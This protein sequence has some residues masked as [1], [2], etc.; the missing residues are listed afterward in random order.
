MLKFLLVVIVV[1][2]GLWWWARGR[3]RMGQPAQKA[4]APPP[5]TGPQQMVACAHCGVH[6]PGA[7]AVHHE[8]HAYCSADHRDAGPVGR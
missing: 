8:G 4:S 7:D 2:V 1:V 3:Q 5:A 6:L